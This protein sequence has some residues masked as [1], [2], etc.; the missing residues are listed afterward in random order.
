[1][2]NDQQKGFV[3][4]I[5]GP[6]AAG[7][8]TIV[9]L[10]TQHFDGVNI[11]TGGMYRA[12]ALKCIRN[13]VD[14]NDP[15]Q[16]VNTLNTTE[17]DLGS[18]ESIGA[19][20]QIFLDGKDVTN[21]IRT[22]QAALGAGKVGQIKQV[23]EI[24]LFKQREIAQ[25]LVDQGRVVIIDGQDI[26]RSV[27]PQAKVKIFLTASQEE[28]ANRRKK[29]YYKQGINKT[30]SEMLK[31]IKMRDTVDF[32]RELHALSSAPEKDGYNVVDSTNLNEAET[33]DAIIAIVNKQ[34]T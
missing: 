9:Q 22:P 23:R 26:A 30:M 13:N 7:K 4:A 27:Y 28:R 17:I 8:G 25:R 5:D 32:T 19:V 18:D 2:K 15:G 31:E 16:I 14:F 3:I 6:A 20:A 24:M 11:Y 1:M 21:D 29:Q 33:K 12:L 34:L 10:L